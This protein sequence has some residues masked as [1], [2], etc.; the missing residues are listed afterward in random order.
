MET[1]TADGTR[2]A[3]GGPLPFVGAAAAGR[4]RD[5]QGAGA[6]VP[7]AEDVGRGRV[8]DVEDLARAKGVTPSYVS[9]VPRL[10]LLA[11]EIVE[12][13]LA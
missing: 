11:P 9:R 13:V 12:A 2:L 8:R 6:G 7:V 5:G 3:D 4:Q 10:T 1:L